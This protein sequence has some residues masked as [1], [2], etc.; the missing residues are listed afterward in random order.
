[1]FARDTVFAQTLIQQR[2]CPPDKWPACG[3]LILARAFSDDEQGRF[4]VAFAKNNMGA[5]FRQITGNTDRRL[6]CNTS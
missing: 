6:L 3:I 2:T 1:M 4:R 5:C